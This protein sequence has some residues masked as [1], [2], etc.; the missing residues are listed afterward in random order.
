M[1]SVNPYLQQLLSA[2]QNCWLG[3]CLTQQL[4]LG[5]EGLNRGPILGCEMVSSMGAPGEAF[6]LHMNQNQW[7]GTPLTC[8]LESDSPSSR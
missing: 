7:S 6:L 3:I 1:D 2:P 4:Q 8:D 5:F